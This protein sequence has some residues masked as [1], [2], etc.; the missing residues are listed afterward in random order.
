MQLGLNLR[1]ELLDDFLRELPD[2]SCLE[3][4]AENFFSA[5]IHHQKLARLRENYAITLHC[6]SMNVGGVDAI[7]Q[8]YLHKIRALREKYQP[9]HV[10]GHISFE[11]YN[12][13]YLHDL[14]PF[15]FTQETLANTVARVEE[16]QAVLGERILLENISYYIE[17]SE[18]SF[19]EVE[20]INNLTQTTDAGILLD[21]N[22]LWINSHNLAHNMDEFLAKINWGRVGEIHLAGGEKQD[23]L[24]IDTHGSSVSPQVL[25]TLQQQQQHLPS[26]TPVIYERDTNLLP[27]PELLSYF[28]QLEKSLC[29]H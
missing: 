16:I 8:D 5:G 23:D 1:L 27:Y 28:R 26:D 29:I 15:P 6:L 9:L 18:N 11:Q 12:G 10:S 24:L 4:I 25:A 2:I 7:D 20:F 22:N 3:I 21:I 13:K 17:F 19:S 14:L